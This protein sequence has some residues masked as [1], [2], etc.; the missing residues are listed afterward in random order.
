MASGFTGIEKFQRDM[1]KILGEK[2]L[3]ISGDAGM[4]AVAL[5][6]YDGTTEDTPVE[7]GP[8]RASWQISRGAPDLGIVRLEKGKKLSM[9]EIESAN[10][11]AMSSLRPDPS[12]GP[13]HVTN[14]MPYAIDI[15]YGGSKVKAPQGMLRINIRRILATYGA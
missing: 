11:Q 2:Q 4:R 1:E 15:E 13:I 3:L 12:M 5:D 14:N 10:S 8:L 7:D 9:A 6:L